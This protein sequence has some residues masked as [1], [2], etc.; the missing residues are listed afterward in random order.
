MY[1][2]IVECTTYYDYLCTYVDNQSNSC[3]DIFLSLI[4]AIGGGI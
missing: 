2:G 1:L 4:F 3:A